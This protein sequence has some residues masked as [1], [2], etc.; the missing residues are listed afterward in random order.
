[1]R[2]DAITKEFDSFVAKS[3]YRNIFDSEIKAEEED[4]D[5][6]YP[7]DPSLSDQI[8]SEYQERYAVLLPRDLVQL[9][10]HQNGGYVEDWALKEEG[11]LS[12]IGGVRMDLSGNRWLGAIMPLYDQLKLTEQFNDDPDVQN[13]K[14]ALKRLFVFESDGH[15]HTCMDFRSGSDCGGLVAIRLE[16]EFYAEKIADSFTELFNFW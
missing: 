2:A 3:D 15:F 13:N 6:F 8:I 4:S 14:E 11:M 5:S 7:L 16:G 1:M 12:E 10:K 9:L